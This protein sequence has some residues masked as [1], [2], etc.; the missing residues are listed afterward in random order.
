MGE[1]VHMPKDK[2]F[3]LDQ[4]T[5]DLWGQIDDKYR[6]VILDYNKSPSHSPFS[7]WFRSK[8]PFPPKQHCNINLNEMSPYEFLLVHTHEL[9][10]D[11]TPEETINQDPPDDVAEPEPPNALLIN[12]AKAVVLIHSLLEKLCKSC[13]RTRDIQ[14]T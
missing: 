12:A 4:N 10:P 9:E 14:P 13:P 1:K 5:K 8:P 11:P 2:W 6:S 7:S 3:G